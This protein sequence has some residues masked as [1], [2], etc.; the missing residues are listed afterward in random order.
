VHPGWRRQSPASQP[1]PRRASL[2][3]RTGDGDGGQC[4]APRQQGGEARACAGPP[5]TLPP[6]VGV[7]EAPRSSPAPLADNG[8]ALLA[9]PGLGPS[10]RRTRTQR[11]RSRRAA[12]ATGAKNSRFDALAPNKT[13]VPGSITAGAQRVLSGLAERGPPARHHAHL[14]RG[15]GLP[16]QRRAVLRMPGCSLPARLS[17]R[18]H[19]ALTHTQRGAARVRASQTR[20]LLMLLPETE[21]MMFQGAFRA[22]GDAHPAAAGRS[23]RGGVR[24][25]R[26]RRAASCARLRGRRRG[27][28]HRRASAGRGRRAAPP[29]QRLPGAAA[30]MGQHAGWPSVVRCH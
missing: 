14:R 17:P 4:A 5:R 10:L 16:R 28:L 20:R 3:A 22:T 8:V 2:R 27:C 12:A 7:A 23:V 26:A 29:L 6:D 9:C 21:S 25:V 18:R 15:G 19:H 30:R 11:R 13:G 1:D 24:G